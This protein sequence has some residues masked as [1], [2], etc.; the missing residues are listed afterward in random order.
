[1]SENHI[2][3]HS[4]VCPLQK[5]AQFPEPSCPTR[6]YQLRER[7]SSPAE[8]YR[9]IPA[10]QL[11]YARRLLRGDGLPIDPKEAAKYFK[12]AADQHNPEAEFEYARCLFQGLGVA[13]DFQSAAHYCRLAADQSFPPA[14]NACGIFLQFGFGGPPDSTEAV[15]YFNRS[16][17]HDDL[18]AMHNLGICSELS[19]DPRRAV[20]LYQRA[21][22]RG[23]TAARNRLAFCLHHGIG[24]TAD[25]GKAAACYQMSADEGDHDGAFCLALFSHYG[26]GIDADL[27][28]SAASYEMAG[29]LRGSA[30]S[31]TAG[32]CQLLPG[33]IEFSCS[34]LLEAFPRFLE[35]FEYA[36]SV[37]PR[38]TPRSI[39]DFRVFPSG[40][41][42]ETL[43]G[44]GVSSRVFRAIDRYNGDTIAL[45][46]I[47]QKC[48][49]QA[50]LVR[51]VETLAALNHPSIVKLVGFSLPHRESGAQLRMEYASHGSLKSVLENLRTGTIPTFW[52]ATGKG[53]LICGI[54]L[55]MRH[56]HS[57]G[58]VHRDLKPS[59]ILIGG[60]G[61]A[62]ISGCKLACLEH[63]DQPL[64]FLPG[65]ISYSAP[66]TFADEASFTPK[67]DVFS[68]GL[69]LY[70]IVTEQPTFP[71]AES[72][73]SVLARLRTGN[74][75]RLP[76][77][78]G[79]F[80]QD[81]ISRCCHPSP[82]ERP[83]F[84]DILVMIEKHGYET[85]PGADKPAIQAFVL[86]TL[87]WE[88]ANVRTAAE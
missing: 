56:V 42:R 75:P 84:D 70:E 41:E 50:L 37:R 6:S 88:N 39:S 35:W 31:A 34:S 19:G 83:S 20:E 26:I 7:A 69:I 15:H 38:E 47:S 68:F 36:K 64:E 2:P 22:D 12:L 8:E 65:T 32:R 13:V 57:R 86:A 61:E 81:L 78:Y 82:S 17:L 21:A 40:I 48:W 66:E 62:L 33:A 24:T 16:S 58:F 1:M 63:H 9:D 29:S 79:G 51:E 71:D 23:H 28:E 72:I 87:A 59:H 73:H 52:N 49:D 11:R 25:L 55:G 85:L 67:M 18:D 3:A 54:V 77:Q 27:E 53:V 60:R 43:V 4:S 10:A 45:K 80:L 5:Q 44:V 30:T 46:D 14:E 74:L 76:D